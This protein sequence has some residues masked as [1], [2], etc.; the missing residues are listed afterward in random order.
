MGLDCFEC[1]FGNMAMFL[2]TPP[3]KNRKIVSC[4]LGFC[5]HGVF[6]SGRKKLKNMFSNNHIFKEMQF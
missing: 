2:H 1:V 6:F 5:L 3:R 4:L